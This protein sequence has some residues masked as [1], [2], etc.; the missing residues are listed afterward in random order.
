MYCSRDPYTSDST[1]QLLPNKLFR[2]KM[3]C[4][5]LLTKV[6]Q[7]QSRWIPQL[8]N[9]Q[10]RKEIVKQPHNGPSVSDFFLKLVMV[11]NQRSQKAG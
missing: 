7:K 3:L 8:Q 6:K 4:T 1:T 9:K 11:K 5:K 10:K 2:M